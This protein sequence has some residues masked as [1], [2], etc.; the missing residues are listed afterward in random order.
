MRNEA[1]RI[2][3]LTGG[4]FPILERNIGQPTAGTVYTNE[5]D[6]KCV[7]RD[8]LTLGGDGIEISTERAEFS[9]LH[10]APVG[11]YANLDFQRNRKLVDVFH[12]FAHQFS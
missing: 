7:E 5:L 9:S 2:K 1:R 6:Y 11:A 12:F 10:V 8:A 4:G 3:I